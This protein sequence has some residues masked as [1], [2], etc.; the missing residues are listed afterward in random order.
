LAEALKNRNKKIKL[1]SNVEKLPTI[2]DEDG[3]DR[4]YFSG[5]YTTVKKLYN[6]AINNK[7]LKS[8]DKDHYLYDVFLENSKW[9]LH[10]MDDIVRNAKLLDNFLTDRLV[11]A[12]YHKISKKQHLHDR[13]LDKMKRF[14]DSLDNVKKAVLGTLDPYFIA[15]KIA[16]CK[17]LALQ[18]YS[19]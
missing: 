18:N 10:N 3:N 17:N 19:D 14:L 4:D 13:V 2:P 7:E 5:T 11:S 12:T 6:I 15:E 9:F 16:A 1:N 8:H